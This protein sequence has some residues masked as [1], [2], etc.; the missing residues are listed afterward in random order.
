MD[1]THLHDAERDC[2]DGFTTFSESVGAERIVYP[3][4]NAGRVEYESEVAVG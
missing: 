4:D 1:P 3:T 2:A